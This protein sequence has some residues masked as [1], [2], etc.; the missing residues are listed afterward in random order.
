MKH[1]P[2]NTA[3]LDGQHYKTEITLVNTSGTVP[4]PIGIVKSLIIYDNLYTIFYTGRLIINSSS[5]LLDSFSHE[6]EN[7]L[8]ERITSSSYTFN[9]DSKDHI[10]I[11]IVPVTEET[12]EDNNVFPPH[13]YKM[14]YLFSIYSEE[15]YVHGDNNEKTKVFYLRDA[16]AQTLHQSNIQWSTAYGVLKKYKGKVNVS[17][18]GNRHR[19]MYTGDAIKQFIQAAL[20]TFQNSFADNWDRGFNQTF[21]TSSNRTS[22]YDDLEAL[23]DNHVSFNR[24]DNCILRFDQRNSLW[25][26]RSYHDMFKNVVNKRENKFGPAVTDM[27]NIHGMAAP[28]KNFNHLEPNKMSEFDATSSTAQRLEGLTSFQF[29]NMATDDSINELV[30]T[31]VHNYNFS[32]KQFAIDC[33]HS[34][35]ESVKRAYQTLYA[36]PLIGN[37][38]TGIFPVNDEKLENLIRST[39]YSSGIYKSE[40]LKAGVNKVLNK[41]LAYAPGVSFMTKGSTHRIAGSFSVIVS[42]QVRSDTSFAKILHGEWLMTNIVH[43]FLFDNQQYMNNITCVK[44]HTYSPIV[45]DDSSMAS[46]ASIMD[47][48]VKI[49]TLGAIDTAIGTGGAQAE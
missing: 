2:A 18:V 21:Y 40:R 42:D 11:D 36:D 23:L 28:S 41:A 29:L 22:A 4:L 19:S 13:I 33:S 14:R 35:V 32:E 39:E 49:L 7:E 20:P 9:S 46:M 16:R 24:Q 6:T 15:E 45:V 27:F 8:K 12:G 1:L 17:Q 43:M 37:P 26:L 10:I 44:P 30:T 5:N 3:I 25:T 34:Q 48:A 31:L 38:P 47:G